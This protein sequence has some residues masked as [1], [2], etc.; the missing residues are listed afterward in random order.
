MFHFK[1][2]Q[3]TSD[4]ENNPQ[5]MKQS[6]F[7]RRLKPLLEAKGYTYSKNTLAPLTYWNTD[8]E[9]LLEKY[10]INYKYRFKVEITKYQ[11]LFE[12]STR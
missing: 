3:A 1:L 6:T 2:F 4:Y 9:K 11:P 5:K 7:T 10:D 8:D 12:K